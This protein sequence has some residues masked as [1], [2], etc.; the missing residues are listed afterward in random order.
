TQ[1]Y[2]LSLHDALPIWGRIGES[3]FLSSGVQ[4]RF[5]QRVSGRFSARR[6]GHKTAAQ[7]KGAK[8]QVLSSPFSSNGADKRAR[9]ILRELHRGKRLQDRARDRGRYGLDDSFRLRQ[10][11]S[12]GRRRNGE[13]GLRRI[14][15]IRR[16]A[17][18]ERPCLSGSG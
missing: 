15:E 3:H 18:A 9:T 12:A 13:A 2:T 1:T 7:T 17:G 8:G 10:R 16:R 4:G 11:P 5:A 14:L 6:S